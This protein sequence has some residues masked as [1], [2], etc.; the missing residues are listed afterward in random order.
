[1]QTPLATQRYASLP[2]KWSADQYNFDHFGAKEWLYDAWLLFSARGVKPGELAPDFEL[3]KVGGGTL[4]LSDLR[5]KPVLL[6]FGS[7][8]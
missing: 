4:R 1:M 8:T 7:F 6:H 2:D 5:D 3:P